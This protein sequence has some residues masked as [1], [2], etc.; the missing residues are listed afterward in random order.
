MGQ[1][2]ECTLDN[3][4]E[5]VGG[6][7]PS[8][9]KEENYGGDIAWITP[10][11]L[12]MHSGRFISHGERNITSIGLNSCST[13]ILPAHSILFSSRAPIGYVAIAANP[14][15]TNQGF[16]SIIPND[17]TD[18]MFLYYLLKFNKDAIEAMGSGTTFKEVSGKTMRSIQVRIPS[19]ISEQKRIASLLD[20]I[21]SKIETNHKIND[22]LQQQAVTLYQSW[23]VDYAPFDGIMP[24]TWH[25]GTLSDLADT[26][27]CGKTPSTK[28][29]EY[30]GNEVPFITIP[31]MHN[32]IYAVST[33][34]S[35][36]TVGAL[37]HSGKMLSR[38]SICVS[39]IG[40]AGLVCLVAE[41]SQTNQ[42]INSIVPSPTASPYYIYL[43]AKTLS[44]TIQNL[45]SGGSTI[46]NLNKG[47]FSTIEALIP[48]EK[49]MREF[50]EI[51]K[52]LFETIHINQVENLRLAEIRDTLLPRLM[53]GEID[54]SNIDI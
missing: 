26:I 35:L 27:I 18:Y 15:C 37:S 53:N 36:S 5:I 13:Q 48:S 54:V 45:G 22:N 49:S 39:C 12:S 23:F 19:D 51:V 50:D 16:K 10:K 14:V 42:Q 2:I 17:K 8:T 46:C 43:L 38:N 20:S 30:Y 31:D 4:G 6:A 21:D 9:K 32:Q 1:W 11:D 47:Q 40:T 34:R 25:M 24:D 3:L 33:E 41:P 29:S 7:T 28:R 44:D 52:P